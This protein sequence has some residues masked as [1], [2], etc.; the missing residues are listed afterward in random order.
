VV[1][2]DTVEVEKAAVARATTARA[3]RLGEVDTDR[4]A[5]WPTGIGEVDRVLGGGLVRG[6]VTLV[7]GEPG[8]GKSTL[9]LQLIG[10]LGGQG[11]RCL[12]LSAEES[13]EQVRQRAE[14]LGSL[15]PN[16]WIV[17]DTSFDALG[18]ALD[19]VKPD[20][21]V[22]DS[23]Q[24]VYDPE[25]GSVPGSVTQV[26][27]CTYRL[28]EMA[29][30]R[31][32]AVIIVG[33]VTKEGGLAGPRVLEHLVD[34]VLTFDGDRHHGLRLLRAVKH[35]FGPTGELG[36]FEMGAVGLTG[37]A[38]PSGLFL[39]DRRVGVSGSCVAPALDGS[40]PL[41]VEVQSLVAPGSPNAGGLRRSA[42]GLDQGRLYLLTAV[43]ERRAGISFAGQDVH[44][45][46]AGGVRLTEPAVDLALCLALVSSRLDIPVPIDIVAVGEVGLGGEVRQVSH[47]QRR[48]A[49]AARLGFSR[50]IV[51]P[52]APDVAG[53]ELIRVGTLIEACEAC[54]L[55]RGSR[56]AREV[57]ISVD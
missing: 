33:H 2:E 17:A 32:I 3:V 51:P 13:A 55:V 7:G 23:I 9:L 44:A 37:L 47:L 48:L 27:G 8:I 43:L 45:S 18:P 29:K 41:L 34:T 36:L 53:L 40:R 11:L 14:R 4:Y 6:S 19:D 38:D 54:E 46:A 52:G 10:S 28:V 20:L 22:V 1:E 26:R 25:V 57:A 39:A 42:Q 5:P 50:A 16:V 49:E 35:R 30:E 21:V 15:N 12:M 24:A 31:G 56:S